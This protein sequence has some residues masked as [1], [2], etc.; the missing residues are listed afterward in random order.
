MNLQSLIFD[1]HAHYDD[2]R[3]DQDR[4]KFLSTPQSHGILGLINVGT[5]LGSS[6]TGVFYAKKYKHIYCSIGVHPICINN[7]PSNYLSILENLTHNKKVVAVGEIGLDY[8]Y[9]P[10]SKEEQMK[11]FEEQLELA[12]KLNLPIIIHSRD[13]VKNTLDIIKNAHPKRFVVHCFSYD[14]ETAA[15]ILEMGGFL[16]FTGILTFKNSKHIR[17]TLQLT[18]FEKTLI[19]TD[20]PYMAPEPFRGER[21]DSRMLISVASTI[22]KQK[23]LPLKKTITTLNENARKFFFE[24]IK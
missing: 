2:K 24:A 9:N 14:P 15:K 13:S 22:A 10:H 5:D 18:P 1:T 23:Q 6:Q 21:C 3:F 4:E 8:H 7:L 19:E 16:G 12:A 11:R 20:C 17:E